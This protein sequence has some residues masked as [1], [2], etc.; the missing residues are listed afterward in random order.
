M[1]CLSKYGYDELVEYIDMTLDSELID[2]LKTMHSNAAEISSLLSEIKSV[3]EEEPQLKI[4]AMKYLREAFGLSM[5]DVT[6]VGGWSGFGGELSD[7]QINNLV[8]IP[9]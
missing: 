1:L 4:F 7:D 9:S 6:A 3:H 5:A 8:Q 2:T